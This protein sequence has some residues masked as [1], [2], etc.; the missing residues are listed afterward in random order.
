MPCAQGHSALEHP[1]LGRVQPDILVLI[2]SNNHLRG[3]GLGVLLPLSPP[4]ASKCLGCSAL[5]NSPTVKWNHARLPQ[6]RSAPTRFPV[7][8]N[9]FL[10]TVLHLS[11]FFMY[12]CPPLQKPETWI[13]SLWVGK[14]RGS[15]RR[16]LTHSLYRVA[17]PPSR[18]EEPSA[19]P[20]P[21]ALPASLLL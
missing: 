19:S 2:N 11:P 8:T 9:V 14:A 5:T 6:P 13:Q 20:A 3:L 18:T 4:A 17:E 7:T 16:C 1:V 12:T 15:E 10:Y 21:Q